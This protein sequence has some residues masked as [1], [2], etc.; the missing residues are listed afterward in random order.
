MASLPIYTVELPPFDLPPFDHSDSLLTSS[1]PTGEQSSPIM[2]YFSTSMPAT[3][4]NPATSTF[5]SYAYNYL[6]TAVPTRMPSLSSVPTA[7]CANLMDVFGAAPPRPDFE[8]F[9][10]INTSTALGQWQ[11]SQ[12]PQDP[13]PEPGANPASSQSALMELS[14]LEESSPE[15]VPR[16]EA[17]PPRPAS[18]AASA[19]LGRVVSCHLFSLLQHVNLF[20]ICRTYLV[21]SFT[22]MPI[23]VLRRQ[24]VQPLHHAHVRLRVQSHP[25]ARLQQAPFARLADPGP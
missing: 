14:L 21:R 25:S 7:I 16:K 3:A 13:R 19:K 20:L 17:V 12:A 1:M 11:Q 18:A 15:V 4:F 8:W 6:P 2:P 9:N 22:D 5:N 23:A 10:A 24:P